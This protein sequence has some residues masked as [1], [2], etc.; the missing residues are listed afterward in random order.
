VTLDDLAAIIRK[1][2]LAT[3]AKEVPRPQAWTYELKWDGYR[4]LAFKAADGVRL[5]SRRHQDWTGEF[6]QVARAVG[7]LFTTECVLDGEVCA[8]GPNGLP[9]FQLLEDVLEV[10]AEAA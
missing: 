10:Q 1:A 2:Q 9:S 6:P 4:I 5:M 7:R 8:I 3:L